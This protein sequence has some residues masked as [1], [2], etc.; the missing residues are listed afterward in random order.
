M[1]VNIENIE[2]EEMKVEDV[3]GSTYMLKNFT[4]DINTHYSVTTKFNT[5]KRN[6]T[7]TKNR[8][9]RKKKKK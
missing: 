1:R 8:K 2:E 7:C 5:K 3:I 9:K 6:A 4:S